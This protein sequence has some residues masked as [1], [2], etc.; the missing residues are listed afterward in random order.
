MID[1]HTILLVAA[2]VIALVLG[3]VVALL[4]YRA[5][6][7]TKAPG[8]R[9]FSVGL[10]IITAG[11]VLVGIF[12]HIIGVPTTTGM[13]VESLILSVGFVVMIVGLYGR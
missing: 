13:V 7:R 6:L 4:A 2:K 1:Q 11:T 12:H 9:Y 5:Y 3:S 10:S 8:L